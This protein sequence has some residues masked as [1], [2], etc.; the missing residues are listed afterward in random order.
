MVRRFT[1]LAA[2]LAGWWGVVGAG[3]APAKQGEPEKVTVSQLV[4][5]VAGA[6]GL[7]DEELKDKLS[8]LVLVERLS[9]VLLAK[10]S[11]QAM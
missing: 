5:T 9:P 10:L 1:F 8:R 2:A 6:R 3:A 7:G 4:E 11:T